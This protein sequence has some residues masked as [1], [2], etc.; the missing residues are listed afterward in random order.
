MTRG[1]VAFVGLGE[2]GL[3]MASRLV[4]A[5]FQ[6]VG[7]DVRAARNELLVSE[8]GGSADGDVGLDAA[9]RPNF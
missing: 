6:V 3:P 9:C 2:M 5:G 7:F 8:G 1:R 4:Q